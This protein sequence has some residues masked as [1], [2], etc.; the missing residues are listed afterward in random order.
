MNKASL[1]L[2]A[3]LALQGCT[4]TRSDSLIAFTPVPLKRA[5]VADEI[6][7]AAVRQVSVIDSRRDGYSGRPITDGRILLNKRNGYGRKMEGVYAAARPLAEYAKASL[8]DSLVRL[9]VARQQHARYEIQ[10]ILHEVDDPH[11]ER[12]FFQSPAN[13]LTLA[14]TVAVM[15]TASQKE[16]WRQ[17]I[18]ARTELT[19]QGVFGG[20]DDYARALPSLMNDLVVRCVTAPGFAEALRNGE[21]RT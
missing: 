5:A 3:A 20:A 17:T 13:Y 15:E 18:L 6:D 1:F 19:F 9:G 8:E 4:I 14:A 16:L 11:Y 10:V 7:G 21:V 12:G 2:L